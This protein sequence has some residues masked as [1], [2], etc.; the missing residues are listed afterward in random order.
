MTSS[1]QFPRLLTAIAEGLVQIRC[2]HGSAVLH[3]LFQ[4]VRH[5]RVQCVSKVQDS[6]V[7]VFWEDL[8]YA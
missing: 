8:V 2:S 7:A 6:L 3:L 5:L 1:E 4:S